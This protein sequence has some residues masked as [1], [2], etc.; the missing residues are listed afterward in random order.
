[1]H[2][3]EGNILF[4]EFVHLL[5]WM[6]HHLEPNFEKPQKSIEKLI[7]KIGPFLDSLNKVIK[8]SGSENMSENKS[9][10]SKAEKNLSP[11]YKNL[12]SDV[13]KTFVK[14]NITKKLCQ[15]DLTIRLRELLGLGRLNKC[16][17]EH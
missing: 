5:V 14:N 12:N 9:S 11:F 13:F 8:M 17:D 10:I 4:R 2:D 6:A 15:K 3:R 16:I 1:M 7:L